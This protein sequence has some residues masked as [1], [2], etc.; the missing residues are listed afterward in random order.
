MCLQLPQPLALGLLLHLHHRRHQVRNRGIVE[1]RHRR[2]RLR[3]L[4]RCGRLQAPLRQVTVLTVAGI[5]ATQQG[6]SYQSQPLQPLGLQQSLPDSILGIAE[7]VDFGEVLRKA[8]GSR[9][10]TAFSPTVPSPPR[11]RL[12]RCGV[13]SGLQEVPA[14]IQHLEASATELRKGVCPSLSPHEPHQTPAPSNLRAVAPPAF[15]SGCNDSSRPRARNPGYTAALPK[16]EQD[17]AG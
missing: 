8:I 17:A 13:P 2:R 9:Y 6:P 1:R 4:L 10:K 5:L 15:P 11:Q 7:S 16:A 14:E 12:A 3:R